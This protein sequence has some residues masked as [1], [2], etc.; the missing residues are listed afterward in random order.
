MNELENYLSSFFGISKIKVA[1]ISTFFDETRVEKGEIIQRTGRHQLN[2]SFIKSGYIRI[3]AEDIRGEKEVTQWISGP[4][5]FITDL[6]SLYFGMAARRNFQ[7]LTPCVLYSIS[8]SN[9][10]KIGH[11]IENWDTLEKLF[12]AKCFMTIEDRVFGLLSMT[13]EER[14]KM[15]FEYDPDIFN[16]VPLQFIASMLGMTPETLSRIR[17]KRIS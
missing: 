8:E 16:Q 2:L 12:I 15:F 3:F 5:S 11:H 7:T 6:S 13:A 4:A 9:F 1:E 10:K 14:Y 17:R